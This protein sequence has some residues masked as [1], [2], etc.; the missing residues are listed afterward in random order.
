MLPHLTNEDYHVL[1]DI[2]ATYLDSHGYGAMEVAKIISA[3][4]APTCKDFIIQAE[5]CGMAITE[6]EWF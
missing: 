5:G 6:L 1:G 2:C 3:F 4:D